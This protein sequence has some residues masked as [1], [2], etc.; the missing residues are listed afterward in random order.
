MGR[1]NDIDW[2]AV[3]KDYRAGLL[4]VAQVAVE[5][6]VSISQVKLKAKTNGWTRDLG[7]A[8]RA[9]TQAK[10]AQI[11]VEALVEESAAQS[12]QQSA[13]LL[14][15]AIEQA[16][17]LAAGVVIRHRADIRLQQERAATIETLLDEQMGNAQN[18]HDV[19]VV[20]QIFKT[21][22]E[23]RAKLIEKDRQA[24]NIDGK[25]EG[26]TLPATVTIQL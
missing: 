24:F 26:N 14:K 3:E 5:H 10:V 20:A 23:A 12:A 21:L 15:A 13:R 6:R 17:D 7:P 25:K 19:A 9:R 1:R 8:I 18:L 4:S 22:V 2:E 11:D 16:S